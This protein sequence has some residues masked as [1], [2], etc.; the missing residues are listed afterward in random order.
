MRMQRVDGE[1]FQNRA[2]KPTDQS[3][4]VATKGGFSIPPPKK[5]TYTHALNLKKEP[6]NMMNASRFILPI[7]LLALTSIAE[8]SD[9]NSSS[10]APNGWGFGI[11]TQGNTSDVDGFGLIF[12]TPRYN[13]FFAMRLGLMEISSPS[14][15]AIRWVDTNLDFLIYY[16]PKQ[17]QLIRPY[18]SIQLNNTTNSGNGVV[19]G[20]RLVSTW[21]YRFGFE[22][23]FEGNPPLSDED[24]SFY[25]FGEGG[26]NVSDLRSAADQQLYGGFN[27][28][29]G[30]G[31]RF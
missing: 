26:P 5:K 17:P 6:S 16:R 28:K 31:Q 4:T 12:T 8:A 2:L 1:K 9:A 7:I 15:T 20:N 14:N 30:V 21:G 27:I 22:T 19:H 25:F 10:E 24:T 11:V 13:E 29:F 23:S 3:F 18:L